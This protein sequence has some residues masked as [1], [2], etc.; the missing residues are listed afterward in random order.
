ME[1]VQCHLQTSLPFAH[2]DHDELRLA[3]FKMQ[4]ADQSVMTLK[5]ERV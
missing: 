1:L 2:L 4:M 3:L 5:G